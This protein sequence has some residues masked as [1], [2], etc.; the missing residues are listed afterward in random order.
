MHVASEP[1]TF[2]ETDWNEQAPAEIERLGRDAS[3]WQK[4][5]ASKSLAE[6]AAWDL[7]NANKDAAQ[8]DL[9]TLNPP[10]VSLL[11]GRKRRREVADES[12][13]LDRCCTR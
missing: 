3:P 1:T 12:R 10:T 13:C 8:W 2:S 6:R 9:V 7:W 5:R 4:Y 11:R